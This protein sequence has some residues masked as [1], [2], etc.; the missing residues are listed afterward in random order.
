MGKRSFPI[1]ATVKQQKWYKYKREVKVRNVVLRKDETAAG[2]MY[3]YVRIVNMHA[4][5]DGK[6]RAADVE[7]SR[8]NKT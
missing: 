3:K 7:Y 4:G 6:V 1:V 8:H 2:Q 5:A